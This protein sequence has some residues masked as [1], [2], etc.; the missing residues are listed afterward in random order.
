MSCWFSRRNVLSPIW[1]I[2]FWHFWIDIPSGQDGRPP[3]IWS[4][5]VCR[6]YIAGIGPSTMEFVSI[7]LVP[8]ANVANIPVG[9]M[10]FCA[11][12]MTVWGVPA[13]MIFEDIASSFLRVSSGVSYL[14]SM[15][16]NMIASGRWSPNFLPRTAVSIPIASTANPSDVMSRFRRQASLVPTMS[17]LRFAMDGK[18]FCTGVSV[19]RSPMVVTWS[20]AESWVFD[21]YQMYRLRRMI[22]Q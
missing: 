19:R 14:S 18:Y 5:S 16:S 1:L 17:T 21:T 13:A 8:S 4:P 2:R 22:P 3:M 6:S 15:S 9:V 20:F 11:P 12:M 7:S 10:R